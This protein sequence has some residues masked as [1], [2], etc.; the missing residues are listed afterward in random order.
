MSEASLTFSAKATR[1]PES[2]ISQF[3]ALALNNPQLISLA[4]GMVDGASLPAGPVAK[5]V[6]DLLGDPA[7]ARVALQYGTTQGHGPLIGEV[8][9]HVAALDGLTPEKLGVRPQDVVVTTGSQQLLYMLSEV[10]L[11]P[12][13]IVITESPSYFV[14]HSV[15]AG[16]AT[17]V[18]TVPM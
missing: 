7:T 3:M 4:A 2:P 8:L 10:L 9:K 18:L 6:A 14:Y 17:R 1:T 13:D 15:L 5:A 12:G 16:N 11:D